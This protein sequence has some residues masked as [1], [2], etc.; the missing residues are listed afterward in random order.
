MLNYIWGG[1]IVFAL[2]FALWFDGRDA[3]QDTY[4]NGAPVPA[5]VMFAPGDDPDAATVAVQVGFDADALTEHYGLDD[6]LAIAEALTEP[7]AGTLYNSDEGHE[8]R[9]DPAG[10]PEP[11]A[12]VA[13]QNL[14]RDGETIARLDVLRSLIDIEANV[15]DETRTAVLLRFER[16]AS[17]LKMQDITAA[18]LDYAEVAVT[19]SLGLIGVL[20]LWMGL[21]KIAEEAGL[22]NALVKVVQPVIRPLFPEIP[23][24]HPALGLIALNL[25]ANILA[26]GNAATP[27]GLKAMKEL[28]SLNP[29]KDTATNPMVMFL[30]MNTASVQIVPS[31]T[32]IAIMGLQAADL[33]IAIILVTV[34]SLVFAVAMCKGF[35]RLPMYRRSSP[36]V[37]AEG[38]RG[39]TSAEHDS[40]DPLA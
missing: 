4:R 30:A 40:D 12:T 14:S 32:V 11:L 2:V 34:M 24:G 27:M 33:V 3:V 1:L 21:L 35:E 10:L 29:K 39:A 22:V 25:T 38:E 15:A 9:F 28:Q 23:K 19:I 8:L 13:S 26:L 20:A 18:S 17:F 31:A 37:L 36:G 16:D 7:R 6:E 5:W